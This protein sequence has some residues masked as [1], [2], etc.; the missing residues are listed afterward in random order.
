VPC[1]SLAAAAVLLAIFG[2]ASSVDY[3][4]GL[5]TLNDY[6]IAQEIDLGTKLATAIIAAAEAGGR[7][8]DPDDPLTRTIWR[9][10]GRLL[11]VPENRARMPPLP[12]EV[13]VIGAEPANAWCFPGGQVLVIEG[14][15][16]HG[17]ARDE[18]ELAALLG[19]E[20]GHAAARHGTEKLT[21]EALDA[22]LG[23]F[24]R[25]LGPRLL[26]LAHPDTPRRIQEA[27]AKGVIAYDIVQE[28]EADIIGLEMMARAGYDP[29]R[30][31]EIWHRWSTDAKAVDAATHPSS[32]ERERVLREHV[33]TARYVA[34]RRASVSSDPPERAWT[35]SAELES[36]T[37]SKSSIADLRPL[38]DGPRV[39]SIGVR[40]PP[41]LL[42]ATVSVRAGPNGEALRAAI[43]VTV[44]RDLREDA[45]PFS[46]ELII[47]GSGGLSQRYPLADRAPLD[48]TAIP[49]RIAL[50]AL[51]P[52]YYRARV[53]VTVGALVRTVSRS[54]DV[55]QSSDP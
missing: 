27:F 35:W 42:D 31:A 39:R 26:E 38:P 28:I 20:M 5:P 14:L 12:W 25:F 34:S 29:S 3:A 15:L 43:E 40:P 8:I 16:R 23:P 54:F 9:V 22:R 30:A 44:G 6:T 10:T 18:D 47:T 46:A 45:L 13:H 11:S 55:G 1:H 37:S 36:V 41:A 17:L 51:P 50:R 49:M 19:H 7:T 33:L 2:C 32:V 53:R 52:G 4:T 24:G 21:L 48:R